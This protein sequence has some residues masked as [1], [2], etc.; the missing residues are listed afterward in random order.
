V[1]NQETPTK[2]KGCPICGAAFTGWSSEVAQ[3]ESFE[4]DGGALSPLLAGR[5]VVEMP[6]AEVV[7]LLL[8]PCGCRVPVDEWQLC[9]T[10][11]RCWFARPGDVEA[12][13]RQA[14]SSRRRD[15]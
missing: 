13:M 9:Q 4:Y 2:V 10:V 3:D 1:T 6:T 5:T 12:T 7:A 11:D 15:G 14:L 8:R